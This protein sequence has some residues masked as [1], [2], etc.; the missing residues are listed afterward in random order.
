MHGRILIVPAQI[1]TALIAMAGFAFAPPA[2]GRM[3]LV[4]IAGAGA[5]AL[6]VDGGARLIGA[7]PLPGSLVVMGERDRFVGPALL[8]GILVLSAPPSWCGGPGSET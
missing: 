4:P 3:L 1:A 5:S 8:K 7:G 2:Q 6:V